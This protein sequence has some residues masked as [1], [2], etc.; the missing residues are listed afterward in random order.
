VLKN[1]AK[2]DLTTAF[3]LKENIKNEQVLTDLEQFVVDN[4]ADLDDLD[5]KQLPVGWKKEDIEDLI[6]DKRKVLTGKQFIND[7]STA[8]GS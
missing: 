7:F 5:G 3:E 6:S 1:V 4:Q 8:P 2:D